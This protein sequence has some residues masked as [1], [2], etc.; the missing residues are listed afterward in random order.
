MPR[1]LTDRTL[2]SLIDNT[3]RRRDVWDT[4]VSGFGVR[5]SPGGHCSFVVRYRVNGRLRRFTIGPYSRLSLADARERAR[6]ALRDSHYGVDAAAEKVEARRAETFEELAK[7]YIERHAKK[8]RSG[9][10][11]IRLLNGSLHRK[12]T[13]KRP[14]V[15]LVTRWGSRKLIEIKRRDVRDLLEE[16]AERA[17]IMDHP[18]MVRLPR[19]SISGR[20]QRDR[21]RLQRRV[22]RDVH[23]PV[24]TQSLSVAVGEISF[25]DL[26]QVANLVRAG[27]VLR[28][29]T[30]SLPVRQAHGLPQ[31]RTVEVLVE[32]WS[33]SGDA[34]RA[35]PET[36]SAGRPSD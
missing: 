23:L 35:S 15:P 36:R 14:H 32:P 30:V 34:Q 28:Q 25:D 22:V 5:I 13:G 10:E 16:I 31:R 18:E 26:Q 11:D 21:S 24:R 20:R 6:N 1:P 33:G 7:E 17:P 4:V 9:R 27:L 29:P 12:K 3:M 19:G 8:K 2:R